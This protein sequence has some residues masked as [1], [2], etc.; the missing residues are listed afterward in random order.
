M[1]AFLLAALLGIPAVLPAPA[2]AARGGLPWVRDDYA[3]AL[4]RARA[5]KVPIVVDVWAPW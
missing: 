1:R 3:G 2:A 4:S 5:R